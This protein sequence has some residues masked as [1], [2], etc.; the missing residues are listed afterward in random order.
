MPKQRSW[1]SRDERLALTRRKM[2]M[3][4]TRDHSV[5]VN[6]M[7]EGSNHQGYDKCPVCG[8]MALIH[9]GGCEHCVNC[10]YDAC[11]LH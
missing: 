10:G 9:E 3:I 7:V 5:E 11:G 4:P 8:T 2:Q 1:L 6:E